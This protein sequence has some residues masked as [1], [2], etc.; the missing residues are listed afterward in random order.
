MQPAG[1]SKSLT[2]SVRPPPESETLVPKLISKASCGAERL[3]AKLFEPGNDRIVDLCAGGFAQS[4]LE[5]RARDTLASQIARHIRTSETLL[6]DGRVLP[7]DDSGS[8]LSELSKLAH[9]AGLEGGTGDEHQRL[10]RHGCPARS[11]STCLRAF[12]RTNPDRHL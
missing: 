8:T 4:R 10:S 12:H 7:G 3:A 2:R 6:N 9:L 1:V 5:R 11:C